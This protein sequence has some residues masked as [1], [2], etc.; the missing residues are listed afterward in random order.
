MISAYILPAFIILTSLDLIVRKN[1][2]GLKPYFIYI[3]MLALLIYNIAYSNNR[4][5]DRY[6]G[7][8]NQELAFNSDLLTFGKV[9]D[10]LKISKN[11]KFISIPD[12][13]VNYSLYLINRPGWTSFNDILSNPNKI[14]TL[15]QKGAKYLLINGD[16]IL[17]QNHF[18]TKY[19][20]RPIYEYGQLKL[21]ALT[22]DIPFQI[23]S[24]DSVSY[25]IDLENIKKDSSFC[26]YS[27]NLCFKEK[28]ISTEHSF[29]GKYSLKIDK[30]TQFAFNIDFDKVN[31]GE[32][33]TI[34]CW[35]YPAGAKVGPVIVIKSPN[36]YYN[37]NYSIIS[38]QSNGWEKVI[39]KTKVPIQ[40]DGQRMSISLFY[41]GD[42][43]AYID[44]WTFSKI[45]IK[46]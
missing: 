46:K 31:S 13:T 2:F 25:F 38:K 37:S 5:R 8:E 6:N 7:W 21:F 14:D 44:D 19:T 11:D 40:L 32:E 12:N 10:S 34:S 1:F 24:K 9:L 16:D 17:T 41:S 45:Y 18:L 23:I 15:I 42:S 27:G 36:D 30:S 39:L 35:R 43:K 26:D 28:G 33:Y 4:L 29:S 20:H 22:N 3:P